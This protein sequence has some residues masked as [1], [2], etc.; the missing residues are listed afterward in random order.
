MRLLHEVCLIIGMT[1]FETYF[2]ISSPFEYMRWVWIF[3]DSFCLSLTMSDITEVWIFATLCWCPPI[4]DAIPDDCSNKLPYGC[5]LSTL[6]SSRNETLSFFCMAILLWASKY[7]KTRLFSFDPLVWTCLGKYELSVG[8]MVR[9]FLGERRTLSRSSW[10]LTFWESPQFKPNT[11]LLNSARTYSELFYC[12][13][14]A[15]LSRLIE[16]FSAIFSLEFLN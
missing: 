6:K 2:C 14:I 5:L 15:I 9:L 3:A 16:R 1:A 11:L 13:T 7:E 4:I 12:L 10:V 8:N